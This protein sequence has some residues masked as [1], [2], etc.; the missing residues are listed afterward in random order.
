MEKIFVT[1]DKE[2]I[3]AFYK[4]CKGEVEDIEEALSI[5]FPFEDGSYHSDYDFTNLSEDKYNELAEKEKQVIDTSGDKFRKCENDLGYLSDSYIGFPEHYPALLV[6]VFEKSFD[7]TGDCET[8]I[9]EY[10]YLSDFNGGK[11]GI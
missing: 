2:V 6:A 8:R 3:A 4:L 5:E 1:D 9:A 11:N 10:V 7:R